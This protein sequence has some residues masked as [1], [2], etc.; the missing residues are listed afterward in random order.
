[1][2]NRRESCNSIGK[3]YEDKT[4]DFYRQRGCTVR[5]ASDKANMFAHIDLYIDEDPVDVKGYKPGGVCIEWT[6]VRGKPGWL[7]GKSNSLIFWI[8]EERFFRVNRKEFLFHICRDPQIGF[9]PFSPPE[10]YA[11]AF[12][13]YKWFRRHGRQ[14]TI[15]ML[16]NSYLERFMQEQLFSL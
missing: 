5:W 4:A 15:M 14:D 12:G 9:P 13:P 3:L 16:P 11:R 2:N 6:N 7:R 8:S 10:G 1:M